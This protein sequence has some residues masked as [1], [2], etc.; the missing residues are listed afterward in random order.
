MANYGENGNIDFSR[1]WEILEKKQHN[2][3]WLKENGIHSNTIAKLTKNQNVTCEVI[4]NLCNLLDCQPG[5][6]MLYT[7][8]NT[9][10]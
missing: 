3:K 4:C 2:K 8:E 1:L 9:Q 6:F 7:K 5:D 10:K